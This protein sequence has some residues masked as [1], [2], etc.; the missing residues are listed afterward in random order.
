MPSTQK[1]K[2]NSF[3]EERHVEET[4]HAKKRKKNR[5]VRS[6]R[7]KSCRDFELVSKTKQFVNFPL[8]VSTSPFKDVMAGHKR[9]DEMEFRCCWEMLKVPAMLCAPF[10]GAHF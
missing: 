7:A 3:E 5:K 4:N 8:G 10:S 6:K 1:G 2:M 9:I